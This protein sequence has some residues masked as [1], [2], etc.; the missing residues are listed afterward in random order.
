MSPYEHDPI[1]G[2]MSVPAAPQAKRP[3]IFE[4]VAKALAPNEGTVLH[5]AL[6]NPGGIWNAKAAQR[7]QQLLRQTQT[8]GIRQAISKLAED[9]LKRRFNIAG[10]NVVDYGE[11]DPETGTYG[12]PSIIQ[13]QQQDTERMR[14][15]NMW[16]RE[17]DPAKKKMLASMLLQANSPW[18]IAQKGE[19][20]KDVK[21]ISP[22]GPPDPLS[23][24]P[25]GFSIINPR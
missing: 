22:G 16:V 11:V 25:P 9:E 20:A 5:A 18:V 2:P 4:R 15:Y 3:N 7:D 23:T 6:N 13:P 12:T 10:N 24:L 14:L 1:P 19:I 17:N 21:A 8:I